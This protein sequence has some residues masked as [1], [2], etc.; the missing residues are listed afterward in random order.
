MIFVQLKDP[1]NLN[2]MRPNSTTE[3]DLDEVGQ[4]SCEMKQE[5]DRLNMHQNNV[6]L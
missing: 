1:N 4:L 6:S 2:L 5:M 3:W